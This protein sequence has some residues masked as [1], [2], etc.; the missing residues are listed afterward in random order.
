M[1]AMA[2]KW[3][4]RLAAAARW[5]ARRDLATLVLLGTVA[6]AG[7]AFVVLADE[8]AEGD[9]HAFDRAILLA[10]REPGDLSEPV[11]P[12]WLETMIRDISALGGMAVLLLLT[13]A[14]AGWLAMQGRRL[15][16]WSLIASM[17]GALA[18]SALLKMA[19]DRPRPDLV[20][21]LSAASMASFP[22]GHSMLS[23]V[24]YL[25]LGAMIAT[26]LER[27]ALKFYVLVLAIGISLLVGFSRVYLGVHW[28]S[29]VLAGWAAGSAWAIACRLATVALQR[30]L[31][32][33]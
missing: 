14:A 24:A 26:A 8:L 25:T 19:F 21:P 2:A 17:G 18:L 33:E 1:V 3:T 16:A 22:S 11:G 30:R 13:F 9:L 31:G 10:M 27:R 5:V 32:R 23:M 15:L 20:D 29:D 12:K 28:P 6:A 7:W 4:E